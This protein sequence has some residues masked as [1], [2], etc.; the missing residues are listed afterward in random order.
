DNPGT[1]ETWAVARYTPNQGALLDDL[2]ALVAAHPALDGRIVL[3]GVS[4]GG[5][6][7]VHLAS[8]A[9]DLAAVVTLTSPFAPGEYITRMPLLTQWEVVHV[10]GFPIDCQPYLCRAIG[11]GKLAPDLRMPL[12]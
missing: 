1:G 8:E 7:A 6:L 10:T 12:L 11:L 9:P 2:R 3:V 4:L 5:M